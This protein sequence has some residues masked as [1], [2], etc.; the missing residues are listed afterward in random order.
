MAWPF[1][2][3][4]TV[5]LDE[6]TLW[7]WDNVIQD[8]VIALKHHPINCIVSLIPKSHE[9]RELR[10]TEGS[11]SFYYYALWYTGNILL[12]V[13]TIW[14]R[15]QRPKRKNASIELE[16]E[17]ANYL[18]LLMP[19]NQHAKILVAVLVGAM[20]QTIKGKL[21]CYYKMG[22]RGRKQEIL[23]GCFQVSY[24]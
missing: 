3:S 24:E 17:I 8:A 4:V 11:D 15:S 5:S 2:D 7:G 12:A 18:E 1:E 10:W 20:I 14:I 13:P 22:W 19:M 9:S 6:N 16:I 21:D 23:W